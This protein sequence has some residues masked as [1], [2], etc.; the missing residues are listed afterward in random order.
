MSK[1]VSPNR[2]WQ[3]PLRALILPALGLALCAQPLGPPGVA[4]LAQAQ[5]I[6]TGTLF[7]SAGTTLYVD[8]D[9]IQD[10]PT[11]TTTNE[12]RWI[13]TGAL[14]LRD[15]VISEVG[16][17]LSDGW[18]TAPPT[19]VNRP[20]FH[21]IFT[22]FATNAGASTRADGGGYDSVID[23]PVRRS[24]AQNFVF[25]TG[26]GVDGTAHRGLLV[27]SAQSGSGDMDAH[28]FFRNGLEDFGTALG[29]GLSAVSTLEYWRVWSDQTATLAPVYEATS[30]IGAL[31]GSVAGAGMDRLTVAG[32]N[33]T[34]WVDL[35]GTPDASATTAA[36]QVAARV[37]DPRQYEVLTFAVSAIAGVEDDDE[38]G[39]PNRKEWDPD[40]DGDGPDDSN[41]DGRPDYRDPGDDDD[42][43]P[44][45]DEDWDGSGSHDDDE[46]D[47]DGVP[48]Y[49]DPDS[50]GPLALKVEK[51]V[52]S[53]QV[54]FGEGVEWTLSVENRSTVPLT[55]T[56]YDA[57]PPGFPLNWEQLRARTGG[58]V[59]LP[60]G[61]DPAVLA[62]PDVGVPALFLHWP[63]LRLEP[64]ETH[65][66][67]F[68]TQASIV[69]DP[70]LHVNQAYAR[71][72]PASAPVVSNLTEA[73]VAITPDQQLEC[74]TVL[75]QV[76]D[77]LNTDGAYDAGEPGLPRVR[78]GEHSGL[79]VVTDQAGR[80]HLPCELVRS[81][82]GE[83]I[84]LKLDASTL[85][86][87]YRI[88]SENPRAVR[89]TRGKMA[90]IEFG[91]IREREVRLDL[92]DCS[93]MIP[94]DAP[95]ADASLAVLNPVWPESLGQLLTIM[96]EGPAR[97]IIGYTGSGE[98]PPALLNSRIRQAETAIRAAWSA[99]NAGKA[100]EIRR[101]TRRQLGGPAQACAPSYLFGL[102]GVAA[103]LALPDGTTPLT[104]EELENLALAR[105]YTAVRAPDG[106]LFLIETWDAPG[107][108][109]T[110][111]SDFRLPEGAQRIDN[112]AAFGLGQIPEGYVPYL[113]PQGTIHLFK[114]P[115]GAS[116]FV[117]SA[118]NPE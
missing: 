114:D 63:G 96:N 97:L 2:A 72:G 103:T 64:G 100:L 77:D 81:D 38:D 9:V 80:F 31:I 57:L 50:P 49:P 40:G 89:L 99:S 92:N 45:R 75:G 32:W 18:R 107:S 65:E 74:A 27:V 8:D 37:T 94:H 21:T 87:N 53:S 23:G 61:S 51:T 101:E 52:S 71:R 98:H 11:N 117:P 106:R 24:G 111:R 20:D 118:L 84:V 12:G 95:L 46:A 108:R 60:A 25:P 41:G 66:L 79:F 112:P 3:S 91:A 76:F 5:M 86:E 88:T 19:P 1:S 43:F 54:S 15:G 93:F 44:T 59:G 102:I 10:D 47:G 16:G 116:T 83:N 85:P 13:I 14:Q 105:G 33:G 29:P 68:I 42:G 30:A 69:L 110:R 70:G 78:M 36:G 82:I 67:S 48:D 28:Y 115:R 109:P 90:K 35:G 22:D 4:G 17:A 58:Y 34:A 26:Y 104:P 62:H 113:V 55:L 7:I 6:N 39:I 56:L 73:E